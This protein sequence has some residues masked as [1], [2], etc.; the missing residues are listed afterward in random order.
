MHTLIFFALINETNRL[1][2]AL[3]FLAPYEL[4]RSI[5]ITKYVDQKDG[6]RENGTLRRFT[7]L[8]CI[9]RK[10]QSCSLH[11]H[12]FSEGCIYLIADNKKN[13]DTYVE[14]TAPQPCLLPMT[15]K[16]S[17]FKNWTLSFP[18][19]WKILWYF[20]KPPWNISLG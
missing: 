12:L 18:R 17:K 1:K 11:D 19:N 9:E 4:C 10:Q 20:R 14:K 6:F 7:A 3:D 16:I 5:R 2:S 13:Y 8:A 15:K